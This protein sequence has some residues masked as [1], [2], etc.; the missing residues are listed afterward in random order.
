MATGTIPHTAQIGQKTQVETIEFVLSD[1][2]HF[3]EAIGEHVVVV[4]GQIVNY[5][6]HWSTGIAQFKEALRVRREHLRCNPAEVFS[7]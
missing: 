2:V 7:W 5:A 3:D 1:G 4:G 6:F